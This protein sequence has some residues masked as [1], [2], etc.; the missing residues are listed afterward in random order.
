MPE[1]GQARHS[2]SE[3]FSKSRLPVKKNGA[4]HNDILVQRIIACRGYGLGESLH[5]L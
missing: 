3:P 2:V 4:M 5:K 1:R